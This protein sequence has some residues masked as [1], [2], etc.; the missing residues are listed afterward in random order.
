MRTLCGES[1]SITYHACYRSAEISIHIAE[2]VNYYLIPNFV[3]GGQHF[4]LFLAVHFIVELRK[5]IYVQ[6]KTEKFAN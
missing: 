2:R 6:L 1:L 5:V 3:S 4:F